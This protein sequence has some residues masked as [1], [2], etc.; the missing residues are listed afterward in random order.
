M[1]AIFGYTQV[2]TTEILILMFQEFPQALFRNCISNGSARNMPICYLNYGMV[3]I[4]QVL[5]Y[6]LTTRAKGL[7]NPVNY[8]AQTVNEKR[9]L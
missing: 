3:K 5:K 4:L 9:F 1:S 7:S 2:A 6:Y 8:I